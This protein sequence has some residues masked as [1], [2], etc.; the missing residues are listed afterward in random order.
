MPTHLESGARKAIAFVFS[1]PGRREQEQGRPAAGQTGDNLQDALMY[2]REFCYDF[3]ENIGCDDWARDNILITNAWCCV[4]FRAQTER[5]EASTLDIRSE[6]NVN[7]LAGELCATK[8][9][10]VCCGKKARDA[11]ERVEAQLSD[12]VIIACLPHLG[13]QALNN[14]IRNNDLPDMQGGSCARR[15]ERIRRWARCLYRQVRTA[16]AGQNATG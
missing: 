15:Q 3:I 1:C 2:M 5:S 9:I 8:S 13:N 16:A 7:R 10:I 12:G 11:V 6:G 14:W 4:E